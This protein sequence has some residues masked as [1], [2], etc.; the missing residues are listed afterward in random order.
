MNRIENI[1]LKRYR[2]RCPRIP[3]AFEGTRVAFLADIHHGRC[4]SQEKVRALFEMTN[5]L[6]PDLVLLGGDY[7]DR[8]ARRIAPF[9]EEAA[10][11]RARLGVFGV[12][13][14]HDRK[15]D[16]PQCERCM[17]RSGIGLL[18]NRGFWISRGG[19]RFRLGGV[20]DLTTSTQHIAPVLAGVSPEDFVL[21][22][23]HHPNYALKLPPDAVD[24]MLCGHTHGGQV[25][26][27]GKWIPPW[28]G[29]AKLKYLT[30]VVHEGRT[31]IVISNG[32]GTVG[33]PVRIMAAPQIWEITLLRGEEQDGAAAK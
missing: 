31:T 27:R 18:D 22:V 26:F 19:S 5:N 29:E 14:N 23:T 17:E 11:L 15:A 6:A 7:V 20:G 1:V 16:G 24:L 33:P 10:A 13:G 21:L 28:P 4:F 9:F 2:Y 32:I 12:L 25:S 30:G 8:D 3:K